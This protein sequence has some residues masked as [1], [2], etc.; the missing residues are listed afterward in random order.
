MLSILGVLYKDELSTGSISSMLFTAEGNVI[1]FFVV[2]FPLAQSKEAGFEAQ[3]HSKEFPTTFRCKKFSPQTSTRE[4]K[5]PHHTTKPHCFVQSTIARC[6]G[7]L[8]ERVSVSAAAEKGRHG[9]SPR[10]EEGGGREE[11]AAASVKEGARAPG[12]DK[13]DSLCAR[14]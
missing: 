3:P 13:V 8:V 5:L 9:G 2:A 1:F 6:F 7:A 11:K 14:C 12:Q 4:G 10:Q